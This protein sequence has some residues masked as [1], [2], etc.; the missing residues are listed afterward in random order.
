MGRQRLRTRSFP[1]AQLPLR[2]ITVLAGL[3][4]IWYGA[5][6][7]LLALKIGP[8][9]VNRLSGYRTIYDHL[10][11]ITTR[12]ITGRVRI[13]VAIAGLACFLVFA[14][15]AW[16]ALPRPYLARGELDLSRDAARGSTT[17]APRA[18]ERA[19]EVA[20]LEHPMVV[21][22]AGRYETEAVNLA[23]T[24]RHAGELGRALPAVQH[25]AA[26]AL[27]AHGLPPLAINVSLTGFAKPTNRE[28]A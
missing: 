8:H 6:T 22:A 4:L 9:A 7:V 2:L 11:T 17:I 15:L 20:A 5:M 19:I 12:D 13:I 21:G 10:A 16:R 27:Q 26:G 18:I 24:F 14:T 23:I 25:R 1:L 28:L 3:A